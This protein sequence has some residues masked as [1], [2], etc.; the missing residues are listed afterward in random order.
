MSRG[1]NC[2]AL[3][4]SRE[5]E[6]IISVLIWM[7]V[8]LLQIWNSSDIKTKPLYTDKSVSH[9]HIARNSTNLNRTNQLEEPSQ[10]DALQ[11]NPSHQM[12]GTPPAS[13]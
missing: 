6:E 3:L 5:P 1:V 7:T 8:R 11:T 10:K 2:A 12:P 13:L 4:H 9:T